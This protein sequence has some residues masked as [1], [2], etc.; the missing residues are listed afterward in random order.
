MHTE[1]LTSEQVKI[2]PLISDFSR[3]FGL[4]GGT[5][6]ALHIGHRQSLDFNLFTKKEEIKKAL[7]EFSLEP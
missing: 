7:V 6:I 1:I 4:A 2:L 5:A 3:D